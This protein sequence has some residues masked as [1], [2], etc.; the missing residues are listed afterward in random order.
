M[1]NT[2]TTRS[3]NISQLIGEVS[4]DT[5]YVE[6]VPRPEI[7]ET[8]PL[9]W[10]NRVHQAAFGVPLETIRCR[11][12]APPHGAKCMAAPHDDIQK[13]RAGASGAG[14]YH[15]GLIMDLRDGRILQETSFAERLIDDPPQ[16]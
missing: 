3:D 8:V 10:L 15:A 13:P 6:T 12:S 5:S 11:L 9:P 16:S 1:E 14:V 2:V 4:V 7:N